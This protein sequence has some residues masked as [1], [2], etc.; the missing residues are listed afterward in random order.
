ML[1]NI[2]AVFSP[3]G[4][5]GN[6]SLLEIYLFFPGGENANGSLVCRVLK[7]NKCRSR[8]PNTWPP[9]SLCLGV[10][11]LSSKHTGSPSCFGLGGIRSSLHVGDFEGVT[12][13]LIASW[14]IWARLP[15]A[16]WV[17]FKGR[18]NVHR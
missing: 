4:F 1:K 13:D 18:G 11:S 10:G 6:L 7:R 3:V 2:F 14:C 8:G 16:S 9:V 12:L 15:G 17:V 5:K